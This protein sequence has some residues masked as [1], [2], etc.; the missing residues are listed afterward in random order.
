[1]Q[2]IK[3]KSYQELDAIKEIIA[4]KKISEF[5]EP[6]ILMYIT[7]IRID[8]NAWKSVPVNRWNRRLARMAVQQDYHALEA[9][10][11]DFRVFCVGEFNSW[12]NRLT[13]NTLD[14]YMR[15][16]NSQ[17]N[18]FIAKSI[19]SDNAIFRFVNPD[20]KKKY[21]IHLKQEQ[22][23]DHSAKRRE[24]TPTMTPYKN[25]EECRYD[26]MHADGLFNDDNDADTFLALPTEQ[27]TE[28]RL[29]NLLNTEKDF[30]ADFIKRLMTPNRN[31]VFYEKKGEV[32]KAAEWR[33][34]ILPYLNASVCQTIAI[35]HPEG[36]ATTPQFLTAEAVSRFWK[37]KVKDHTNVEMTQYFM[38]FP[39]EVLCPEMIQ[40]INVS[41]Q[42]LRHAPMLLCNSEVAQKYL[43]R[44]PDDVLRLQECYQTR[45]RILAD[46]VPINKGTL[47]LIKNDEL[48]TAIAYAFG[49]NS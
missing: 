38:A 16:F 40:N 35:A 33:T 9:I 7:A 22:E 20:N 13:R 12:S 36:S 11:E 49:L 4:G 32:Q 14:D 39:E 25:C 1:M 21:E 19:H 23:R 27:Q 30:P 31:A 47:P 8:K 15:I 45:R 28:E 10:P 43:N 34:K 3:Q 26:F 41:W 5:E 44:Y 17:S 46:R 48:R 6:T 18:T 2:I 37:K 29:M 24:A 42:V